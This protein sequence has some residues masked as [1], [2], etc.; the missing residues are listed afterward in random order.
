MH[1]QTFTRHVVQVPLA[2]IISPQLNMFFISAVGPGG[3]WTLCWSDRHWSLP[4]QVVIPAASLEILSPLTLL[5]SRWSFFFLNKASQLPPLDVCLPASQNLEA[6]KKL[7]PHAQ[8]FFLNHLQLFAF[9]SLP[10]VASRLCSV[11]CQWLFLICAK[12]QIPKRPSLAYPGSNCSPLHR[13]TGLYLLIYLFIFGLN[14]YSVWN[15][16][17]KCQL[18]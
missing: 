14:I 5:F 8:L 18:R 9:L 1:A 7:S 15:D 6:L 12:Q 2:A 4:G 11:I 17:R 13:G 16:G 10:T 3:D